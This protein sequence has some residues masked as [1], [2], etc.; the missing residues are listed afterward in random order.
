V[1]GFQISIV[2]A[3]VGAFGV[4]VSAAAKVW[5]SGREYGTFDRRQ[6][7][8]DAKVKGLEEWRL[9]VVSTLSECLSVTKSLAVSL[10]DLKGIVMQN[11]DRL[12]KDTIGLRE[13]QA[14]HAE[15]M[16]L[17]TLALEAMNRHEEF[18]RNMKS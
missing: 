10:A 12:D 6:T 13:F 9:T 11:Q 18:H 15:V 1:T 8:L 17:A 14:S 5:G 2:C 7:E 16:R 4:I 3:L